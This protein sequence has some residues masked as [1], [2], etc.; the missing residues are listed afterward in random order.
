[1]R[2]LEVLQW[3]DTG[4]LEKTGGE[5]Q[6]GDALSGRELPACVEVLYGTGSRLGELLW[7]RVTGETS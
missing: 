6:E 3:K 7:V 1:M 4:Y 2:N 5:D